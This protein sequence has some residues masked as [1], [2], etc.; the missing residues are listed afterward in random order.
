[1]ARAGTPGRSPMPGAV[2]AV[3]VGQHPVGERRADEPGRE[4]LQG[5]EDVRRPRGHVVAQAGQPGRERQ[6]GDRG[7]DERRPARGRMRPQR[8]RELGREREDARVVAVHRGARGD[9]EGDPPARPP[10][11]DRAQQRVRRA[12]QAHDHQRVAAGLGRVEEQEG[13]ERGER[14]GEQGRAGAHRPRADRVDQRDRGRARQQR[15]QPQELVGELH[16]RG[17]PRE[18]ERQRRRDL[19]VAVDLRDHVPEAAGG[20][21]PAGRE[22]VGDEAVAQQRQPQD[23]AEDRERGHEGDRDPRGPHRTRTLSAKLRP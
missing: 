8:P 5:G 1:M 9:A 19:R 10:V 13:G 12:E 22:L 2:D 3:R 14:G 11:L 16:P 18:H 7:R 17:E 6:R 20:D 21:H 4:R 15:R 23:H